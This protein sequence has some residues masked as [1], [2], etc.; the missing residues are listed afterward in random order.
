VDSTIQRALGRITVH[1]TDE[2]ES[3]LTH[4]HTQKQVYFFSWRFFG[5]E[6]RREK[7]GDPRARE[8]K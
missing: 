8:T 4:T 5:T 3:F 6:S 1:S 2:I 7:K